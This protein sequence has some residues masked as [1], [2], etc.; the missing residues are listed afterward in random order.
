MLRRASAVS[1]TLVVR[2]PRA[3]AKTDG[4]TSVVVGHERTPR[5]TGGGRQAEDRDQTAAL[6]RTLYELGKRVA[7][8]GRKNNNRG[9]INQDGENKRKGV[10][11]KVQKPGTRG[12]RQFELSFARPRVTPYLSEFT[13]GRMGLSFNFAHFMGNI[14]IVFWVSPRFIR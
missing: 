13:D 1:V 12:G 10:L 2:C 9:G 4:P 8:S 11:T 3:P 14:V 6:M 5:P 7:L